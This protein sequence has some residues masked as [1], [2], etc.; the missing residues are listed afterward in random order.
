MPL[1]SPEPA[2][3]I[4]HAQPKA[5]LTASCG[6]EIDRVVPYK[7]LLDR[8]IE[9]SSFKPPCCI[10][11]QRPQAKAGLVPGRDYDWDELAAAATPADCVPVLATDPLYI[12]YSSGTT[13]NPKGMV[14]DNGGHLVALTWSMRHIYG[15]EP[16]APNVVPGR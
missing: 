13:G 4:A 5:I 3:R 7:P 16:G 10:V 1:P 9:L 2:S 14:R 11:L 8:A 6:I 12:L 15:V